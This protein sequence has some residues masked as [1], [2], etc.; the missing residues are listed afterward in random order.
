MID[1]N[2][3]DTGR[4]IYAIVSK[5]QKSEEVVWGGY[6]AI[7][8]ADKLCIL[9]NDVADNLKK[10]PS[11]RPEQVTTFGGGETA[12]VMAVIEANGTVTRSKVADFDHKG[13]VTS[14]SNCQKLSKSELILYVRK[15]KGLTSKSTEK[16]GIMKTN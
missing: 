7:T 16:I 1:I 8:D 11:K 15:G 2:I 14:I 6:T 9:Y 12:L 4:A 13:L 5:L 3:N 10:D